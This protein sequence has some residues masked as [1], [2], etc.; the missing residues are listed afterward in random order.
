M[1]AAVSRLVVALAFAGVA[2]RGIATAAPVPPLPP[3]CTGHVAVRFTDAATTGNEHG[4]TVVLT[5]TGNACTLAGFPDLVQPSAQ[6]APLPVGHVTLGQ[7][8]VLAAGSP[9]A[10]RIRYFTSQTPAAEPCSLSVTANGV[11]GSTE[12]TLPF[13]D[14]ASVTQIDVTGYARGTQGPFEAG[15][16]ASNVQDAPC[17]VSDL[18][19][20]EIRTAPPGA[21]AADA[22]YA[23]QNRGR[24]PCT[25]VGAV[26]IRLTGADG[27]AIPLRFAVRNTMAMVITLV[28]EHEASFTVAYAP[29]VPAKCAVSTNIDVFV[30][31]QTTPVRAPATL[32][33]CTGAQARVSNVR[34]GVPL[35]NG[36]ANR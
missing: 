4:I 24:A 29:P 25:I 34:N 11:A 2:A 3:L 35:P 8:V 17:E 6:A 9:A 5:S 18:T 19:L 32:M 33:A 23:M 20:R 12:G 14:C 16:V 31:T 15:L 22:I 21:L 36:I 28:P 1:G 10:F 26:G 7:P 30:P 27:K 13:A